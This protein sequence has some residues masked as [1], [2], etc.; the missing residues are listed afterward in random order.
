[1]QLYLRTVKRLLG[2]A[3]TSGEEYWKSLKAD[4]VCEATREDLRESVDDHLQGM[5]QRYF[6]AFRPEQMAQHIECIAEAQKSGL[7]IRHVTN[8]VTQKSEIVIC[9]RDRHALF[10]DD[11]GMFL[12][13]VGGHQRGGAVYAAG[14]LG[15]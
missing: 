1:M 10:F 13:A 4:E 9:T 5:G 11:R 3:E 6:V 7:A 14:R 15:Y 12:V 2:R 8:S